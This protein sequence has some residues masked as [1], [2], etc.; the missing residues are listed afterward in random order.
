MRHLFQIR[1]AVHD[2]FGKKKTGGQFLVVARCAHGH[3]EWIGLDAD[4]E[5]LL[6]RHLVG[7]ALMAAILFAAEDAARTDALPFSVREVH[8]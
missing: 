5:W 8:V 1:A 4:F 6:D 2:S 3:R 7:H